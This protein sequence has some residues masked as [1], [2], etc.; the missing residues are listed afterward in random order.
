[1]T[2]LSLYVIPDKNQF[3]GDTNHGNMNNRV[4]LIS[5]SHHFSQFNSMDQPYCPF[6]KQLKMIHSI[7]ALNGNISYSCFKKFVVLDGDETGT[8]TLAFSSQIFQY[9]LKQP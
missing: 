4:V 7:H 6:A 5:D 9:V 1:M 3:G 8:L 2:N